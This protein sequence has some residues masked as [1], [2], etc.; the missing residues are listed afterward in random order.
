MADDFFS[1]TLG[2]QPAAPPAAVQPSTA[3]GD[4]FSQTLNENN[5]P[6]SVPSQ[7]STSTSPQQPQGLLSRMG[8][9]INSRVQN[10]QDIQNQESAGKISTFPAEYQKASEAAQLAFADPITGLAKAAGEDMWNRAT[11]QRQQQ[12]K[13]IGNTASGAITSIANNFQNV[14][15]GLASAIDYHLGDNVIDKPQ[16][17]YDS[18]PNLQAMA[19]GTMNFAGALPMVGPEEAAGKALIDTMGSSAAK[20][21]LLS[22]PALGTKI[23]PLQAQTSGNKI[24]DMSQEIFQKAKDNNQ[25]FD[26]DFL[27]NLVS[28][29]SGIGQRG[30][31]VDAIPGSE[32]VQGIVSKWSDLAKQGYVPDHNELMAADSKINDLIASTFKMG[33]T[34]T[35]GHDLLNLKSALQGAVGASGN[36]AAPYAQD[37]KALWAEKSKMDLLEKMDLKA[38]NSENT[39]AVRRRAYASLLQNGN[40]MNMFKNNPEEV[41]LIQKAA[42]TG[43]ASALLREVGS[44]L[45]ATIAG[46]AAGSTGGP[47]GTVMGAVAGHVVASAARNGADYLGNQAP[48]ALKAGIM[49]RAQQI[50]DQS[51]ARTPPVKPTLSLPSPSWSGAQNHPG[52]AGPV[53]GDVTPSPMTPFQ[54]RA[55]AVKDAVAQQ[56]GTATP[57]RIFTGR[58]GAS[59]AGNNNLPETTSTIAARIG[60]DPRPLVQQF[61]G[62]TPEQFENMT[63]AQKEAVVDVAQRN[64]A[65]QT[66]TGPILN[67]GENAQQLGQSPAGPM[68][69]PDRP[70]IY[71]PTQT[72][73]ETTATKNPYSKTATGTSQRPFQGEMP[74]QFEA[75]A[76][77]KYG[78]AKANSEAELNQRWQQYKASD[79]YNNS[80]A[81]K[82]RQAQ[83]DKYTGKDAPKT[84]SFSQMPDNDGRYSVDDFNFVKSNKGGPVQFNNQK[85][86][87]QWIL[88]QGHANS[89]DQ[90]FDIANHPSGKGYTVKQTGIGGKATS[91]TQ[92][93][94]NTRF[95]QPENNAYV[96]GENKGNLLGQKSGGRIK[97]KIAFKLKKSRN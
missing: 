24:K 46:A 72:E 62:A 82:E 26:S 40:A 34:D 15:Q 17:Y 3:G 11:P 42:Q 52:F 70:D 23:T 50:Y 90:I 57:D 49:S 58:R 43:D 33:S 56:S 27:P 65:A 19:K 6:P 61:H 87:A 79:E 78:E 86:A 76:Q 28:R 97:G 64:R 20:D 53:T 81:A 16:Q 95:E 89:P 36:T 14:G 83:S 38:D 59:F 63:P 4:F 18:S 44:R 7:D 21:A 10:I 31:M 45:T 12:L 5:L 69:R 91:G 74:S 9:D 80:E 2:Q 93:T 96:A 73:T 54:A 67:V 75:A 68:Q 71:Q 94:A 84:S 35:D 1:Q 51:M 39:A 30:E 55:Q 77:S 29:A 48:K 13:D 47:I 92:R 85:Q 88:K 25:G 22:A 37:A 32:R 60:E 8:N 66:K 41:A